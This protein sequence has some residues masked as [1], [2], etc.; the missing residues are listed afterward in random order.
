MLSGRVEQ[1]VPLLTDN[2]IRQ[3]APNT[4]EKQRNNSNNNFVNATPE[5]WG[6]NRLNL[7]DKKNNLKGYIEYSNR[8][9]DS[10][11]IDYVHNLTGKDRTGIGTKLVDKVIKENPNKII[12]WDS[13]NDEKSQNFKQSYIDKHPKLAN[14]I[15]T[16]GDYRELVVLANSQGYNNV[17]DYV[18]YLEK[19]NEK[20]NRRS[21]RVFN[22]VFEQGY[23]NFSSITT[24][25]KNKAQFNNDPIGQNN[26]RKIRTS[27]SKTQTTNEII[28]QVAPKTAKKQGLVKK[29]NSIKFPSSKTFFTFVDENN[30]EI[31]R[32]DGNAIYKVDLVNAEYPK[33]AEIKQEKNL[34]LAKALFEKEQEKNVKLIDTGRIFTDEKKRKIHI[35][36]LST[37]GEQTYIN[38][39][40]LPKNKDLELYIN[41]SPISPISI[42]I[43]GEQVGMVMP[44]ANVKDT[45]NLKTVNKYPKMAEETQPNHIDQTVDMVKTA[46]KSEEEQQLKTKK[47]TDTPLSEELKEIQKTKKY[48]N[49]SDNLQQAIDFVFENEPVKILTGQEFQ[50]DNTSIVEKVTDYYKKYYPNGVN[51]IEIGNIKFDK[52]GVK[53]SLGHGIGSLK[54]SAYMA[55]PDV[56]QKGFVFDKQTNWKNR[57]YD[58]AVIIAPIEI[59]NKTYA[60]EVVI[61]KGKNRQG[62]YLHEVE[63]TNKL[64]DV[65]KTV[66]DS[67]PTSS[68]LIIT[69]LINNLNPDVKN[70]EQTNKI[71][72]VGEFLKGNRKQDTSLSWTDLESMN[73]LVRAKNTTKA[74]IY[75][76]PTL[77]ELKSEGYS[78]FG[79]S[80]IINVYNKI[81]SKPASRYTGKENQK[82]YVD[83]VNDTMK[84]IKDYIRNNPE[85]F[86]LMQLTEM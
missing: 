63:I 5:G 6:E 74:K 59:N 28:R 12:L 52:E 1:N 77:E 83:M 18:A 45:P 81:N 73:D 42:R 41:N 44:I 25:E 4:Y 70:S 20:R 2:L 26:D 39:K 82:L 72:D 43:N 30:N 48:K 57:G 7:T 22:N 13:V 50:K 11:T 33:N 69:D 67:T 65:F 53:D 35:F 78:D 86:F 27:K 37:N 21:K 80:L 23:D 55:V 15:M 9:N 24:N 34:S 16:E 3:I 54:A 62:F 64:A 60:C 76:K 84:A 51:N 29:G 61:K 75:P 66:N 68:K 17:V 56:I 38:E 46:E 10:V 79:A 47:G 31:Y 8:D 32:T 58:T 85:K 49:L 71:D 36:K 19:E 14:K 40:Y